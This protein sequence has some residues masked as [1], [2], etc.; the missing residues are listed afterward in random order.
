MQSSTTEGVAGVQ[1]MSAI[2]VPQMS[3]APLNVPLSQS[4]TIQ[5]QSFS[6]KVR[7]KALSTDDW[8]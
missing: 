2:G 7:I 3:Q 6:A 8:W 5:E 4:S 1:P